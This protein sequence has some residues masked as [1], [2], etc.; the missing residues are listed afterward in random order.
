MKKKYY[1]STIIQALVLMLISLIL[2]SPLIIF[3]K[4]QYLSPEVITTGIFILL[5]FLMIG[6][7]YLVN[8]KRKV[9]IG[10]EFKINN[11]ELIPLMA[12]IVIIFQIGFVKSLNHIVKVLFDKEV[13]L[14]NPLDPLIFTLGAMLIGPIIEEIFFRGTILK[15]F[16]SNYTPKMAII[17]S[18]LIFGVIHIRPEQVWGAI[19]LGLFFGWIYYKTRSIGITII[20]HI[21]ANF[22]IIFQSYLFNKYSNIATVTTI[23]IYITPISVILI[24]IALKRLY[25]KMN[26]SNLNYNETNMIFKK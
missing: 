14:S 16:L 17:V 4:N 11:T 15:G 2:V 1:P 6:I 7:S 22:S 12:L 19:L 25:N 23:S 21:I 26:L 8:K 20:L 5:F 13:I 18:A 3:E 10:N 9:I 24:C